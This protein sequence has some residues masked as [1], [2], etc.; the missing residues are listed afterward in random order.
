MRLPLL[1][2]LG[3]AVTC[4]TA[5]KAQ[6]WQV[7]NGPAAAATCLASNSKGYVFA[8]TDYSKVYRTTDKGEN[9]DFSDKGIDDGVNFVTITHIKVDAKDVV[10]AS[11]NGVGIVRSKDDGKTWQKLDLGKTVDPGARMSVNIKNHSSGSTY[12]LVG[13]DNSPGEMKM[14][15]SKDGGDS[16]GPI[17]ITK[18]PS[19]TSALFDVFMSP[20]SN[21]IFALVSYNKGLFRSSDEGANWTRI[22]SDPASGESDDNFRV[23]EHDDK[24]YLYVGRNALPASTKSPNAIIM[25]S[26][27]DGEKWTYLTSGWDNTDV[28]NN[29]VS[30]I[31]FGRNG[32]MFATTEKISGPFRATNYGAMWTVQRDGL[33]SPDGSA[34]GIIVTKDNDVFVAIKGSFVHRHLE[35]NTGI[36]DG[37]DGLSPRLKVY[38]SITNQSVGIDLVRATESTMQLRVYSAAGNEVLP[39]MQLH[40]TPNSKAHVELQIE[41]LASG[42]Y[43]I[44]A[45][46]A[47]TVQTERFLVAR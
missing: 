4:V 29:R 44:V 18:L 39:G 31:A 24:G 1:F 25:K 38:P 19:A 28:T 26:T 13:Y 35:K 2:M 3:L 41:G 21:K 30:G 15:M 22:D 11:V 5:T 12:V 9:W 37:G 43:S 34:S 46:D 10:Y 36:L 8:G 17:P 20:N 47:G 42:V 7:S 16:F 33:E 32:E 14:F 40:L 45:S 6:Y 27:D 23:M